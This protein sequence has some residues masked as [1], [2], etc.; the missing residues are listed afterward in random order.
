M[1]QS[2]PRFQPPYKQTVLNIQNKNKEVIGEEDL[3][4]KDLGGVFFS[5]LG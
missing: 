2:S 3:F 1:V 5:E 4:L